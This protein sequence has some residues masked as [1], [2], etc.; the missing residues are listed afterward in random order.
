VVYAIPGMETVTV[1]RDEPYRFTDTG[2]LTMDVYY[3]PDSSL[4]VPRPAVVFVTG[5]SDPGAEKMLGCRFKDM[6]SFISWAH[7]VAVSGIVGI[8]YAN[9]D[10]ADVHAVL[11]HIRQNGASLGIDAGRIGVWACSGHGPNALSALIEYGRK[12]LA[13]AVLAYA[14]TLD[15]DGSTRVADAARQFRF[16]TPAAGK[17]ANDIPRDLPLFL[18]RAGRDEMPGL[19]DAL[20]RFVAA[21]LALNLPVSLVNHVAGPHAFD[22]FDDTSTSREI[23]KQALA[24]LQF[25]LLR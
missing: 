20:D 13:C 3:P 9:H 25:H 12:G 15:L 7:L 18:A 11:R 22:L 6:G 5:F 24:F 17:S 16:V 23:V 1:R 8:T 10:P 4:G 21:A 19:N 2:G 14:Y